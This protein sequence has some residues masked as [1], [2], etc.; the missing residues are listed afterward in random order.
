MMTKKPAVLKDL[1]KWSNE[2]AAW[3][4]DEQKNFLMFCSEVFRQ[5]LLRNYQVNEVTY[6]QIKSEG[7]K[8]DGF[9]TYI[10]GANIEDILTEINEAAYH[11]ERNGNAK[12]I[13]FD[14]SIKLTRYLHRKDG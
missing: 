2:I 4:R 14:L 10:H 1:I 6:M 11:I 12:I 5:A 3:S 13:L 9:S 7:F 8:W